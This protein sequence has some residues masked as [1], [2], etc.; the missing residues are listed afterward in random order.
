MHRGLG[1]IRI[2]NK[3]WGKNTYTIKDIYATTRSARS[4]TPMIRN[5]D[6]S[7]APRMLFPPANPDRQGQG[8][9]RL[10]GFFNRSSPEK[11]LISVVTVVFNAAAYLEQTIGSVINQTY[12]NI[13]YIIID[14]A[15][16]DGSQEIIKKYESCIF[17]WL[18]EPDRGIVDA[19]NKGVQLSVGDYVLLLHADDYLLASDVIASAVQYLEGR[20]LIVAYS[21]YYEHDGQWQPARPTP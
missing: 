21:L 4:E 5:F 2:V 11:P 9:L 14:G 7:K 18:S 3:T 16:T 8:G 20:P 17:Y 13:E 12:D 10:E 6:N 15:S 1:F 19:M